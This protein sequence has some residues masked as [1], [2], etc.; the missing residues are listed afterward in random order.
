[1]E[2][3]EGN[4]TDKKYFYETVLVI[5]V[6]MILFI[7]LNE[8]SSILTAIPAVYLI[9][10]R[11][12]RKRSWSDIGFKFN[13]TMMDI[14]K[15][16]RWII[17]VTFV[18]PIITLLIANLMLP[19]F[20]M[21]VKG[22][23]PVDTS[24]IIPTIITITIGTFLEEIIFRGFVQ[25]RLGWFTDVP[26]A[27][28]IS[29]ILFAFMHYSSGDFNIVIFDIITLFIDSILFGIIYAK[30]KNVFTSWIAHYLCDIV[31]IIC[32]WMFF[33]NWLH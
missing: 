32:I 19:E 18:S 29:S 14:R 17:L 27:I 16:W 8:Y 28:M 23:L 21:H 22:R 5:M 3:V 25:E 10:E 11:C 30:T 9:L 31:A 6:T 33:S 26:I 4:M 13:N 7:T 24:L 12:F 15:V 20:I 1:M 2:V